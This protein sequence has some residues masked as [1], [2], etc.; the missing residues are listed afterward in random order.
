MSG[1]QITVAPSD[2]SWQR[3]AA[4]AGHEWPDLFHPVEGGMNKFKAQ[5]IRDAK[6]ICGGCEVRAECLADALANDRE[7]IWG[8][9]TTEE[10]KALKRRYMRKNPSGQAGATVSVNPPT[11]DERC[12]TYA[13]TRAHR[14]RAEW[15]CDDCRDARAIYESDRRMQQRARNQE[16]AA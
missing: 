7:G 5:Q 14:R 10:R 9:T 4:C 8:G 11:E 15:L 16:G 2:A 12:G 13:G 3:K 6:E 1:P